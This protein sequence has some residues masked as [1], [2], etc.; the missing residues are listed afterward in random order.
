[1]WQSYVESAASEHDQG[2]E[3]GDVVEAV[4][5]ADGDLDPVVGRLEPGVGVSQPDRAQ[6]VGAA[7]SYLLGEFDDLGYAR[8]GRPEHPAVQFR[9]GLAD[10]V[11]EQGAQEFPEPPCAVELPLGVRVP[12]A[13]E[14]LLLSVGQVAGVLQDG[15]SDAAH[16]LR[17]ILAPIVPRL[18]PQAFPGLVERVAHPG[19]D[20]EPVQYAFGVRAVL[21][22]ARVDPA[23]PVAGDDL[24]GGAPFGRQRLEEQA[25][26]VLAVSVVRP[27]DPM[28]LVADDDGVCVQLVVAGL[29]TMIFR[30]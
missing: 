12:Q 28:P 23:G 1:M 20:V 15:V 18:V 4:G 5:H 26:H 17:G 6:D 9:R 24:D 2:D 16:A 3:V 7:P 30:V 21:G 8:M 10:R 13:F 27:D 25:E 14:R 19:D 11:L 22:D 29:V